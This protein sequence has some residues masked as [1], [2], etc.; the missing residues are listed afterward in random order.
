MSVLVGLADYHTI[1]LGEWRVLALAGHWNPKLQDQVL[2]LVRAQAPARHPQT[3]EVNEVAAGVEK[4]YYL[5]VFHRT[6]L[7]AAVKDR[8]RPSRA[9]G[10]WRQS[11]AL[12]AAGFK[13]PLAIAVG[14]ERGWCKLRREFVLTEKITGAPLP[15]LLRRD[16]A[17]LAALPASKRENLARFARLIRRFHDAGFVHGDLVAANIFVAARGASGVEF[18]FMDNDRTHRYPR[19]SGQNLWKRNL[20][21]LNRMPLAGISL[22]DRMRFMRAYLDVER[23]SVADRALARWLEARTRKRRKECDGADPNLSFRRLMRWAPEMAGAK[24]R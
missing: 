22:Q 11:L 5:K 21:Q 20:I 13:A 6:T 18:Y 24:D 15:E 7:L 14:A 23:L 16:A 8:L 4:Q 3:L 12:S 10:S 17:S 1:P 9:F 2:S 19:W